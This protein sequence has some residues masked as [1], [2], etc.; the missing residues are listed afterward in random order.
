[1]MKNKRGVGVPIIIVG[2]FV[3]IMLI[4]YAL[5]YVPIPALKPLRNLIHY[6][7]IIMVFILIQVAF[8][9]LYYYVLKYAVKGFKIYRETISNTLLDIKKYMIMKGR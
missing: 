8:I 1:M 2:S 6:V 4:I 5:T 9:L 3:F 7:L